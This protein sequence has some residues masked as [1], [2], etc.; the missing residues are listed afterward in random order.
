M[1]EQYCAIC[2]CELEWVECHILACE[3]GWIDGYEDDP[4]WFSPGELERCS[5]C[6]GKGGEWWCPDKKNHPKIVAE[7]KTEE[8]A[9]A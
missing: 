4:L 8:G 6:Q 3:D 7:P 1:S 9:V 5:E 2:G